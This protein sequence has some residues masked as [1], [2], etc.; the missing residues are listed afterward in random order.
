[1]EYARYAKSIA[2]AKSIGFNKEACPKYGGTTC[3]GLHPK[4]GTK[5]NDFKRG[6]LSIVN[7]PLEYDLFHSQTYPRWPATHI[8]ALLAKHT[9]LLLHLPFSGFACRPLSIVLVAL[10]YVL[11]SRI[12]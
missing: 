5:E 3:N 10:S 12:P 7:V 6:H 4:K 2:H 8:H 11:L 1:M 9:L